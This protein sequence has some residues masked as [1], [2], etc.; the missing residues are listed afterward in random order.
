MQ[1]WFDPTDRGTLEPS[2]SLDSTRCRRNSPS[3]PA[4]ASSPSSCIA[5][6]S[7]SKAAWFCDDGVCANASEYSAQCEMA[8]RQP[9]TRAPSSSSPF[10]EPAAGLVASSAS[11]FDCCGMVEAPVLA[12]VATWEALPES[13]ASRAAR[14]TRLIESGSP[15]AS[16]R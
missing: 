12:A 1:G 8:R 15:A 10:V 14:K 5:R 7:G 9:A 11:A 3:P 13:S 6:R 2:T 4:T 16:T